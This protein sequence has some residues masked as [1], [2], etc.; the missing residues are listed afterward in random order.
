MVWL[1]GPDREDRGLG[2]SRQPDP[3]GA[4]QT[5][6]LKTATPEEPLLGILRKGDHVFD[7]SALNI[8]ETK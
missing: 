7:A 5:G 2:P 4:T 8:F 3:A 1:E 6:A